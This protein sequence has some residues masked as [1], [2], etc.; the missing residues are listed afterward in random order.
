MSR[1]TLRINVFNL[2]IF[3]QVSSNRKPVKAV[4]KH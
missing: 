1:N 4:H 3:S 2:T